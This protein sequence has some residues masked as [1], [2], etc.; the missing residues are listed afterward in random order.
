MKKDRLGPIQSDHCPINPQ[1]NGP[2]NNQHPTNQ[3]VED[4]ALRAADVEAVFG[5]AVRQIVEGETKVSKLPRQLV[6]ALEAGLSDKA[7]ANLLH[8]ILAM[9]RDWRVV[10]VKVADR[11]VASLHRCGGV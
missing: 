11:C 10:V 7:A 4:T 2:T 6:N 8:L 3:Q 9:A 1:L 5:P